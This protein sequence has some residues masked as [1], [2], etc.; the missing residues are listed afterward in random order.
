MYLLLLNQFD[1]GRRSTDKKENLDR[2][3]DV[4]VSD[5]DEDEKPESVPKDQAVVKPADVTMEPTKW[6]TRVVGSA[7]ILDPRA[8]EVNL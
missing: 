1:L 3:Y 4:L 7:E 5:F 8:I 2:E 6:T